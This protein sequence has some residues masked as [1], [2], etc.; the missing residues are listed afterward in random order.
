MKN[1][2]YILLFTLIPFL[3]SAQTGD[4]LVNFK[5]SRI[6]IGYGMHTS[7]TAIYDLCENGTSDS[8]K[9]HRNFIVDFEYDFSNS[10]SWETSYR[11][12]TFDYHHY[13]QVENEANLNLYYNLLGVFHPYQLKIGSGINYS[14]R[15]ETYNGSE[16]MFFNETLTRDIGINGIIDFSV[17]IYR[18]I[19]V[20]VTVYGQY[21]K[22]HNFD[23]GRLVKLGY[24]F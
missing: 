24:R 9:K 8:N 11:Y 23:H 22:H 3:V 19:F 7:E 16:E 10:W 13:R 17:N 1:Q 5:K 21:R 18:D 4:P 15:Q 20:G 2:L 6:S 14:V 12:M